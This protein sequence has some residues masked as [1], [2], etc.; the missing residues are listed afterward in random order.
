MRRLWGVVSLL[1][2]LSTGS[3]ALA[4]GSANDDAAVV[5]M[6][7]AMADGIGD[8]SPQSVWWTGR[9]RLVGPTESG[10]YSRKITVT[11]AGVE[12]CAPGGIACITLFEV[13]ETFRLKWQKYVTKEQ[14]EICEYL[15]DDDDVVVGGTKTC[16]WVTMQTYTDYAFLGITPG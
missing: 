3:A 9:T 14:W 10:A 15:T 6:Q 16:S 12:V 2:L 5:S 8:V 7:A 4:A 1:V 13:G 11:Y